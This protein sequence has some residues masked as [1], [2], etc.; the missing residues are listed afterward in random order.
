M[1]L[2]RLE[3]DGG[4][5]RGLDLTFADGLNVLIGARGSGK[6]SVIEVL[7]YCLGIR[8]VTDEAQKRAREQALWSSPGFVDT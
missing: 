6:T 1:K 3:V 2:K 7:R 4:F 8:A 5:L